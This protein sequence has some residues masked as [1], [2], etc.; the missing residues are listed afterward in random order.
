MI[1]TLSRARGPSVQKPQIH[2]VIEQYGAW[3]V[4]TS[5]VIA[6]LNGWRRRP[7]PLAGPLPDYL[8]KDVGLDEPHIRASYW[9]LRL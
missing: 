6:L 8:R 1:E 2:A 3:R 7:P 5:A 4:L 9:D